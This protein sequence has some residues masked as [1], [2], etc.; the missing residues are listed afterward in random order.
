VDAKAFTPSDLILPCPAEPTIGDVRVNITAGHSEQTSDIQ[1]T[2]EES[3]YLAE[4]GVQEI[5]AAGVKEVLKERPGDPRTFIASYL[6]R[7]SVMS[8]PGKTSARGS[9]ISSPA[10]DAFFRQISGGSSCHSNG[11]DV[12]SMASELQ[13]LRQHVSRQDIMLDEF[14]DS[15]SQLVRDQPLTFTVLQYNIL[16]RYLGNN[17]EPWLLYGP[18]INEERR[19]QIMAKFS[20]KD[21]KGTYVNA[22]WP[23]YVKGVL[24]DEEIHQVED[25]HS[26]VFDWSVRRDRLVKEVQQSNCDIIAMEEMDEY[27]DF[28]EALSK[29]YIGLFRKRPRR[30]SKDGCAVFWRRSKFELVDSEGFD[31][32]DRTDKSG[33]AMKDRTCL[34]VLL[35][36]ATQ[37]YGRHESRVLVV[38]THLARNPEDPSQTKV[39]ARQAAQLM[40]HLTDFATRHNSIEVP[41]VL[42]GDLN[43]QHFGEVRGIARTVFQVS[44]HPCHNFLFRCADVPTGPTSVT[45]LRKVRIDAVMFQPKHLKVLGIHVPKLTGKIPDEVQASDHVAVR[46]KFEVKADHLKMQEC[47]RSWLECVTGISRLLPMTDREIKRAFAFL[48]RDSTNEITKRNLQE[49]ILELDMGRTLPPEKQMRFLDCFPNQAIT[50]TEFVNA[51]KIKF[52]ATRMANIGDLEQAFTFFDSNG[53][54]KVTSDDVHAAFN[55]IVPVDFTEE[56]VDLMMSQLSDDW[57]DGLDVHTFCMALCQCNFSCSETSPWDDPGLCFTKEKSLRQKLEAI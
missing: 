46:V 33:T 10:Q 54:G 49:S 22:G 28:S 42:M 51:Y 30:S 34:L 56:E 4:H 48:D 40:K 24:S 39:R 52:D 50:F 41:V 44:G 5:L 53:D 32:V 23:N 45:D 18:E 7:G 8:S 2:K 21:D 31:F 25:V 29:D 36:W 1:R 17:T 26:R 14:H 6:A 20:E 13:R 12:R 57:K 37:R 3:N 16:A 19:K 55:E 9:M 43:A 47:A 35:R 38:C 27:E 15:I 11:Q